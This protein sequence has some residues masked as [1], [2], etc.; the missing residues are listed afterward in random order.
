MVELLHYLSIFG[1]IKVGALLTTYIM[2]PKTLHFLSALKRVSVVLFDVLVIIA[3][4]FLATVA[5]KAQASDIKL[6]TETDDVLYASGDDIVVNFQLE[7]Y[8]GSD[9]PLSFDSGCQLG[10]EIFKYS[11]D[12]N[13]YTVPVYNDLL[14]ERNCSDSSTT[15]NVPDGKKAVWT[16]T[17]KG[18]NLPAG[19]YVVHAYVVGYEH[20]TWAAQSSSFIQISVDVPDGSEDPSFDEEQYLCEGTGGTYDAGGCS[21]LSGYQWD[22]T[23]GCQQDIDAVLQCVNDGKF[24]GFSTADTICIDG[25]AA[26]APLT[27][28]P[29]NDIE[30][31]WAEQYIENLYL[32]GIVQG[33]DDGS[34]R[35]DSYV[36]RAELTK[37]ALSAAGIDPQTPNSDEE[38]RFE[39]VE[40]WQVEWVYPA[41]KN[42]IVQGYSDTVFAPGQ[43]ITRAEALKIAMLAFGIDV[44]DTSDEWAFEDTIGHWA[45]S[46]INQ[47]YLDFIVS[48]KTETMFYPDD[49]ITRA[50]AAKIINNLLNK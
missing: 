40:G 33:Y 34:F 37:M 38:F 46:Y 3:L 41:W 22:E 18:L 32:K 31:H 4:I 44:P 14:Y 30:G 15:I 28:S 25:D 8:S 16:R 20:A 49:Y 36:N 17:I 27:E 12:S 47:A 26:A 43:N 24:I 13:G 11:V 39:D 6:L 50:E 42:G 29:F 1:T 45:I 9:L 23:V 35:P 48:G 7:N 10:V 19:D 5:T 21:C 2:S